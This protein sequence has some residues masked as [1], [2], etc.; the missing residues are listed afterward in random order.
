MA[1]HW[2][3]KNTTEYR[4]D[5]MSE[6]EDFHKKLQSQAADNGYTLTS[7]SWNK[8]E[9]V[10]QGELFDEYYVVKAAFLFNNAKEPDNPFFKVEFPKTEIEISQ[11]EEEE[12]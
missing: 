5:T 7:F 12:W 2:I 9:V 4:V 1:V 11:E 8:K 3:L 6:V 10:K